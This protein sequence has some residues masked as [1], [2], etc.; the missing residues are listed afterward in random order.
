M[1]ITVRVFDDAPTFSAAVDAF[2]RADP[3]RS[4]VLATALSDVVSGVRTYPGS[5]WVAA[6][7]RDEV[8]GVAMRTPPHRL[9]LSAMPGEAA[10]LVTDAIAPLLPAGELTGIAGEREAVAAAAGR[11]HQLR[12]DEPVTEVRAVRAYTLDVLRP[13]DGVPGRARVAGRHDRPLLLTWQAAF[14]AETGIDMPD[15]EAATDARL[16][17]H[18]AFV[19]WEQGSTVVSLAGHTVQVAGMTRVGPVYTPPGLRGRGYGAAVTAA[20]TRHALDGGAVRV[21]LFTDLANPTSN[22]VYQAIGYRPG[23]DFVELDS[24]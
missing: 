23:G 1:S 20:A 10:V 22:S 7:E 9:W 18:G 24:A 8:V 17:G 19:L 6:Y 4:T 11:W 2:V 5:T 15:P 13:P 21:A 16:A 12:P 3:V 14:C